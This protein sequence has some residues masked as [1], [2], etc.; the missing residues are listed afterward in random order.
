MNA[1][2]VAA[3][4]SAQGS[5]SR[6][7]TL[8]QWVLGGI[9][10]SRELG[11]YCVAVA[12]VQALSFL[13]TALM[14]VQRPD[15]VR[16]SSREAERQASIVFRGTLLIT[17]VLAVGMAALA[18]FLCVTAFGESFRESVGML[19]VLTVGAFGIVALKLL[20]DALTARR[21]PMLD[22]TAIWRSC[23]RSRS[24]SS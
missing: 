2:G 14:L 9:A 12:W 22:T 13:P 5:R 11:L 15:L 18:P 1:D 7:S 24:T 6:S 3:I 16:A 8:D 4:N 19:R 23:A 17:L 20:G 10:G 21:K